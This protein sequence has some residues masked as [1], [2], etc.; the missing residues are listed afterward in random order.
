[1]ILVVLATGCSRALGTVPPEQR[2]AEAQ[3]LF[4]AARAQLL[5]S[6]GESV[7][8]RQAFHGAATR[9]AALAHD[10]IA[11]ANLYVNTGN[12]YHF[13]GD[14]ARALLWYLRAEQLANTPEIRS[15][16]ATLRRL[17]KAR[18]W[19]VERPS[20][21]RI[22]MSWHYD[23]GRRTKQLI[24]LATY[25]AGCGLLMIGVL[26]RRRLAIRLGVI[27]ILIGG[28]M[29]VSDLVTAMRPGPQWAVVLQQTKGHTGDGEDYSVIA[30]P[31][32]SGQE[33]KIVERRG[34]WLRA[35]LPGD[36][37]CWLKAEHCEAVR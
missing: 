14:N 19:P 4:D 23:L 1:L 7:E 8:A 12:A 20:I 3:A 24:L 36:V 9:F 5:E 18:R 25:P 26:R 34:D 17:C 22:L 28:L 6:G 29:G 32:V 31:V 10:G 2:F 15:G 11:S 27:L 13:A 37:R 16:L 30:D 35:Q 21:G 33:V